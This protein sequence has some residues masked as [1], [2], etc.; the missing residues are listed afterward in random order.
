MVMNIKWVSGLVVFSGMVYLCANSVNSVG[1][2]EVF[3]GESAVVVGEVL[4]RSGSEL[5]SENKEDDSSTDKEINLNA[6][7]KDG[8]LEEENKISVNSERSE[9]E[10]VKSTSAINKDVYKRTG[11]IS[12]GLVTV[13]VGTVLAI[14]SLES[15]QENKK[16]ESEQSKGDKSKRVDPDVQVEPKNSDIEEKSNELPKAAKISILVYSILAAIIAI[17]TL[18]LQIYEIYK[19]GET[20]G[21]GG[22][23]Y[24]IFRAFGGGIVN[25]LFLGIPGFAV[26]RNYCGGFIVRACLGTN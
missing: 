7:N 3:S 13:G 23:T 16:A 1:A 17:E 5:I 11:M 25:G 6:L 22:W 12:G 10:I 4:P 9:S 20:Y 8:K 15:R 24:E 18:I 21:C 26:S 2:T 19:Y 14:K